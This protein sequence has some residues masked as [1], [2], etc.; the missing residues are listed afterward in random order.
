MINFEVSVKTQWNIEYVK[1][2]ILGTLVHVLVGLMIDK[3]L[4][5]IIGDS[6]IIYDEVMDT[7]KTVLINSNDKRKHIKWIIIIFCTV[8]Y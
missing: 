4:K 2:M 8:F 1:K 3:Y 7:L 5:I 6:V